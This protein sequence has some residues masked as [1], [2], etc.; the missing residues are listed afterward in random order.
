MYMNL[1]GRERNIG[2]FEEL[3]KSVTPQLRVHR[4]HHLTQGALSIIEMIR[5]D[6]T[7]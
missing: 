5:V 4:V 6:S 2:A 3:G 7:L 1:N